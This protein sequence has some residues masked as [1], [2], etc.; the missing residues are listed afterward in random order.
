M[1]VRRNLRALALIAA[2]L[3]F[4]GA[5]AADRQQVEIF[6]SPVIPMDP[7]VSGID[8]DTPPTPPEMAQAAMLD[9][10]ARIAESYM[11][12]KHRRSVSTARVVVVT[13]DPREEIAETIAANL[14]AVLF[15][16]EGLLHD[17]IEPRPVRYKLVAYVFE[18]REAFD[19][20][21]RDAG[22]RS[23]ASGSYHPAGL[24]VFHLEMPSPD[25]L[26]RLFLHEATHA[27][28]SRNVVQPGTALP[29][30]LDEGFA[31]Y[32]G[33]STIKKGKLVPGKTPKG[34]VYPGRWGRPTLGWSEPRLTL[35]ET[36]KAVRRGTAPTLEETVSADPSLFY[37]DDRSLYYSMSWL[38][39]HFLR[40][41]GPG[42]A[43]EEFPILLAALAEGRPTDE[44]FRSAYGVEPAELNETFRDYVKK[45]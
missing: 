1:I 27:F 13:D 34:Q 30:W 8:A 23:W 16:L 36:K 22:I 25:T 28:L 7:E 44:A 26:L 35:R 45:F 33:N 24:V 4:G 2:T 38:L 12:T 29:R 17:R 43:D 42:W 41:G 11:R 5:S 39:V 14:E 20:F 9:D 37:G 15:I 18:R 40:H 21:K 6:P 10:L 31:E 32:I 19:G 3:P